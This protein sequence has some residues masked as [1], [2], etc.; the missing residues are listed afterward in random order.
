M[1]GLLHLSFDHDER[2]D[3]IANVVPLTIITLLTLLF[4]AY[5][6]WGWRQWFLILEVFGLHAVPLLT[7]APVTYI[8]VKV[9]NES[10]E[11]GESE[12]ATSIRTWFSMGDADD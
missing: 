11:S 4:L 9:V 10:F 12:T 6:P 1:P 2:L 7:L 5:N 3:S 8:L